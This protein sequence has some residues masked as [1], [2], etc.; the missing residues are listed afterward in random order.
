MANL[1]SRPSPGSPSPGSDL[2]RW[3]KE[4]RRLRGQKSRMH[5]G[6]EARV[7]TNLAFYF[8]EHYIRQ[9]RDALRIR[10]NKED[11][12]NRLDLVFNLVA[13]QARGKIGRL[14]SIDPAA[15]ATPDKRDVKSYDQAEV[16]ERLVSALSK[17][18]REHRLMWLRFFWLLIGGVVV[19]HTPWV[20]ESTRE[21]MAE[22]DEAGG[23]L[24]LD[25]MMQ[26]T[27]SQDQVMQ[28]IQ[29]GAT[30][31]RFI[32]KETMQ[33]V[34]D[35]G[36]EIIS[37][38][39]FFIDASV[40]EVRALGP[41]QC[42]K[43]AQVKSVDWIVD[44]FGSEFEPILSRNPSDLSIVQSN[45]V[46]HSQTS[47]NIS[48]RDM[49]PAIQGSKGADDPPMALVITAYEPPSKKYPN[50][51]RYLYVPDVVTLDQD[52]LPYEAIPCVDLHW[53]PNATTFWSKDFYSDLVP[54]QKFLNK[55]VSQLG[56][57]ANAQLYEIVLL[58]GGLTKVDVPSD[59]PGV[60]ED[61][62][63]E[64]GIPRVATLARG[65][66]PSW[67]L[68]SIKFVVEFI[69]NVGGA[70]LLGHKSF[71]GQ[72]RGSLTV[73]M[74][75]E[76]L[77]SEDGPFFRHLGEQLAAIYQQR[78]NRVKQFYEPIRTL[79][80]TDDDDQ[81]EVLVF[82]KSD[83][84][85]AGT[86][87]HIT[88]DRSSLIP[89]LAALR[90]ARVKERLESPLA[91][92][93]VNPRTGKIDPSKIAQDLRYGDKGR[94][95]RESQYRKLAQ[96]LIAR[97]QEGQ[98]LDETIP[99]PF[100]D[101]NIVMDELEATM[102]TTEFV[103]SAS[104]QVKQAFVLFHERCRQFLIAMQQ[105]ASD[106]VQSQQMNAAVAQATQMAAAKAASL[107]VEST[108]QQ[109]LAQVQ[110]ANAQPIAMQLAEQMS[111]GRP[112]G[113]QRPRPATR[114]LPQPAGQPPPGASA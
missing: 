35:V 12:K 27:M 36:S 63:G 31:E 43:I 39:N 5:G 76:I 96:Q 4:W 59:M 14:S 38:L 57:A 10:M 15:R 64:D 69:E 97:L 16:V 101:H 89:E 98:P 113:T 47:A 100:W 29:M 107:A 91:I 55:R 18:A 19:E 103:L 1:I 23:V 73:P 2:D 79:H 66:L 67:F 104:P 109:M 42:C 80:Y 3:S 53:E 21:P 48:L 68:E 106:A 41:G 84:L 62:L 7:L 32:V 34:G 83:V 40:P 111:E 85:E 52:E 92:L 30:P 58:G 61:G 90:E 26:Q 72:L 49:I 46:E 51:Q 112:A 105:S 99:Y 28:A 6:V 75:Q 108:M 13:K 94:E 56:E 82:H 37:P 17:R 114:A 102:S 78:V 77:D 95:S 24:W 86:E 45:I 87:F 50:G 81:E 70:S 60:I 11:D 71:P 9:D 54:A 8:S 20:M 74:L 25:Q 88:I 93:Y 44:N 65:Q 33:L 110:Q 22:F